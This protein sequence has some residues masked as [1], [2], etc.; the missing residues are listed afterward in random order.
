MRKY[1]SEGDLARKAR[2]LRVDQIFQNF[3]DYNHPGADPMLLGLFLRREKA[4]LQD[5]LG[6]SEQRRNVD[7]AFPC[8]TR[9]DTAQDSPRYTPPKL[10]RSFEQIHQHRSCRHHFCQLLRL[11]TESSTYNNGRGG[12]LQE[13]ELF[14]NNIPVSQLEDTR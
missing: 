5:C 8:S 11:A 2:I 12:I 10:G 7:T 1:C 14:L 6:H 3:L 9:Q 13:I 4:T